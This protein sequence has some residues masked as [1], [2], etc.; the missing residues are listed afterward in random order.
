M[1][2]VTVSEVTFS[3]NQGGYVV[4]LRE[5]DSE[6]WLP[7]FVGPGEAQ[8]IA[9]NLR[10]GQLQ[11]PMTFDLMAGLLRALDGHVRSVQISRLHESTFYADILLERPDGQVLRLDAR[12]SDAIPLAL[13]LGLP[14]WVLPEIM[15]AAG[16]QGF[17]QMVPLEERIL[18]LEG[19]LESAVE[20]EDFEAAARLRDQIR[21]YRKL[22]QPEDEEESRP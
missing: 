15:E 18:Q 6:R 17:P 2:E 8:S 16:Q 12:P 7:I 11:R 4:I 13:R 19:E 3:P 22:I 1:I 20:R 14:V 21:Y 5:K 10:G 9:L